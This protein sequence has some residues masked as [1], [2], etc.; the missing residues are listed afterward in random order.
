MEC[1]PVFPCPRRRMHDG[2]DRFHTD[3]SISSTTGPGAAA[4]RIFCRDTSGTNCM[5]GGG[6]APPLWS[7]AASP[8][9][10]GSSDVV[11][12]ALESLLARIVAI[13]YGE[14]PSSSLRAIVSTGT[15]AKAGLVTSTVILLPRPEKSASRRR[16]PR[17]LRR[18]GFGSVC[19][20]SSSRIAS[21][22]LPSAAG[23]ASWE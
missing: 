20:C 7:G 22:V 10:A 13:A 19:K 16:M 11:D 2:A 5:N 9:R 12:A 17:A 4:M 6:A 1:F 3:L 18:S 15:Q 14:W 21:S 8:C 23:P